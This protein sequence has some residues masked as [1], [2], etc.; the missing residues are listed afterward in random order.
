[1]GN[2]KD[3]ES[4]GRSRIVEL[5]SIICAQAKTI[6]AQLVETNQPLPSFEVNAEDNLPP[7][8]YQSQRLLLQASDELM[9]LVQGPR[10][11]LSTFATEVC[12]DNSPPSK[13]PY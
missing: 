12:L 2:Q 9:A 4:K 6:E 10:H 13:P 5:A 3:P 11:M 8:L 7:E 1:M